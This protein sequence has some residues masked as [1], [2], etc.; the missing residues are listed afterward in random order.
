M[1]QVL[2]FCTVSIFSFAF[3]TNNTFAKPTESVV[4]GKVR[5]QPLSDSLVR[6]EIKGP[7]GFEN[8]KTF[9][10]V[11]RDWPGAKFST[12]KNDAVTKIKTIAYTII[13]PNGATELKGIQIE[14]N[15]GGKL[16]ECDGKLPEEAFLKL[17]D[18]GTF[19]KS[20]AIWDTPR[21]VPPK[22][23]ALPPPEDKK[24][25]KNSGWD[26]DNQAPD[27]Y[28]FLP[29]EKGYA[30]IK[31]DILKLTGRIPI[32]PLYAFG[33]WDSRYHPY[34]EKEAL[35]TIDTYREKNIPL[36][37]FVV[38]TD[39]RV[40]ASHGYGTNK[41]LFPDMERF[42]KKAHERNVYLMFNDHPEPVDSALSYKELKY[43]FDGLASLLKMGVD[44]WWFDRNW[45]THLGE[46]DKRLKK[47]VWG[48]KLYR[49][50]TKAVY[51]ERRPMIMANNYGI[52]NGKRNKPTHI[53]AHRFPICWTGDTNPEW[54][55]LKMGIENG[56]EGGVTFLLPYV[57]EDIGGHCH[58]QSKTFYP[59]L[60]TR[61]AQFGALSPVTRFHCT[62]G[63]TRFPWAWGEKA[64]NIIRDYLHLRYRLLPTIY[65]AARVAYED[66]TPILRRCDIEWP[67]HKS[68]RDNSQYLF[69]NDILIAPIFEM[70]GYDKISQDMLTAPNGKKGL[71]AEYF[72]NK[73]LEGIPKVKRVDKT[74][75]FLWE[76]SPAKGI[77]D[78]NFSV[79]WTGE[80]GPF[81]KNETI[82]LCAVSDDGLRM[83]FDDKLVINQWKDQRAT[84]MCANVIVNAGKKYSIK[85]EFFESGNGAECR[86]GW[87]RENAEFSRNVWIPPGEWQD[88]WSGKVIKGPKNIMAKSKKLS[89]TPMYMRLGGIV[90][91]APHGMFSTEK[92]WTTVVADAYL[93]ENKGSQT[94][95][96]YEDDGLSDD[97]L[98]GS[99]A[100]TK[101]KL[102]RKSNTAELEI[103]PC[104]GQFKNMITKRSWI[105]RLHLPKDTKCSKVILNGKVL[106]SSRVKIIKPG[107]AKIDAMPFLGESSCPPMKAGSV[108]EVKLPAAS[109]KKNQKLIYFLTP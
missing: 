20:Y 5:V 83:W 56:V 24:A 43:R 107:K 69:G 4:I 76:N 60:F 57:N 36:D 67:E 105:A 85:I 100:K 106:P 86:L 26:I 2:L 78:D 102:S 109:V 53:S 97:Y 30:Q 68:A 6:L 88:L 11:D 87:F 40:G 63:E 52:G 35:K 58:V 47:E 80:I 82:K 23:G 1:K 17:P 98:S 45:G 93:P 101:V 32:P 54:S 73:N 48:M 42:I 91:T 61:C 12:E 46:P 75:D 16:Y 29:G 25:L 99:F 95:V 79:R 3:I 90:L 38:D 65:A 81:P 103:S 51:P 89:F 64:E 70:A 15:T 92:P 96:L 77:P 108:I 9:N 59:E 33:T 66:G 44:I 71:M 34:T 31:K 37:V 62:R 14:S 22:W 41:K 72:D 7:K 50:V 84:M 74:I 13:V 49:D 21:I 55:Y 94:R 10:V 19:S 18:P 104:K 39:W 27:L 28:V 8:R